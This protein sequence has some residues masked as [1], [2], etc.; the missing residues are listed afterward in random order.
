M[1]TLLSSLLV[2]QLTAS[3]IQAPQHLNLEAHQ[4][5]PT[6]LIAAD[7]TDPESTP[8]VERLSNPSPIET[9]V[10]TGQ[11]S[12]RSKNID[13]HQ[14]SS[15]PEPRLTETSPQLL[16]QLPGDVF[17]IP[18]T[19]EPESPAEEPSENPLSQETVDRR[20]FLE[21]L[22]STSSK[23]PWIVN[24][25][26]G[27]SLD[28]GLFRP[29]KLTTYTKSNLRFA[30]NN[31][32]VN[33]LG[34]AHFPKNQQFYWLLDGNRIVIE[35][36]GIQGGVVHQGQ[37]TEFNFSQTARYHATFLG[38]QFIVALPPIFEDLV[39]KVEIG[40]ITSVQSSA[41][42]V[43]NPEGIPAGSIVIDQN[44]D[45][46][47]PNV[48]ILD[49]S[50]GGGGVNGAGSFFT[51]L[52]AINTPQVLQAFPTV[53]LQPLLAG[54]T[55]GLEV[56]SI[57]LPGAL[58]AAGIRF[59]DPL[60]G[61]GFEFNA[62]TTST[63]GIK[64]GQGIREDQETS[65]ERL[66]D[67]LLQLAI[68]PSLT[69]QERD[70]HYLN[71]L[72][73]TPIFRPAD[74]ELTLERT[75]QNDWYRAYLSKSRQRTLLQYDPEKIQATY[76]NIFS[77][78]GISVTSNIKSDI[79]LSQ[80]IN[81][82]AGLLLGGVFELV[83]VGQLNGSLKAAREKHKQK[84]GFTPLQTK[85]TS[86]QRR[87]INL[88]LNETLSNATRASTLEQI[89]GSITLPGIVTP[90]RSHLF[91]L[92]TGNYKRRVEFSQIQT[93][94]FD[95]G[96]TV[97]SRLRLSNRDFGPLGFVGGIV[98]LNETGITP[99]NEAFAVETILTNS[100]GRQFVQQFNS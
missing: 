81:S 68:S 1:S 53:N 98:P 30:D 70:F 29:N 6:N 14:Q 87:Q 17:Q 8:E 69:P 74:L 43:V 88:R 94:E 90:D 20:L 95:E 2:L 44:I 3:G 51:N 13:V 75:V 25:S 96:N 58:E 86:A 46:N 73:W 64:L 10:E 37:S 71:A 65:F 28:I 38:N 19:A 5:A 39:G 85:A 79:D 82:S 78:P 93:S 54:S 56:G 15:Q 91:Q 92:R 55:A 67:D 9:V 83:N 60:T 7:I 16:S 22:T 21:A 41:V 26:D 40:N 77:N 47:A 12:L 35:T 33:Q 97:F 36:K 89:S 66:H 99:A 72:N 4:V 23:Y 45:Y 18:K 80:S 76:T 27:L 63:P 24:P 48:R 59:G 100:D 49:L 57:I 31:P 50:A 34:F 42:Q 32:T 62:A 61:E 11:D 84:L 52:D